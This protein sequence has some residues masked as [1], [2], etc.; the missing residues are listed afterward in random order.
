MTVIS[1]DKRIRLIFAS[2]VLNG[3]IVFILSF[4]FAILKYPALEGRAVLDVAILASVASMFIQSLAGIVIGNFEFLGHGKDWRDFW[5]GDP[6]EVLKENF[7]RIED[8]W[9][10]ARGGLIVYTF[11]VMCEFAIIFTYS[12][13]RGG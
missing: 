3:V 9:R 6:L 11:F 4:V 10:V 5:S 12:K 8:P 1:I 13:V 2:N 7:S